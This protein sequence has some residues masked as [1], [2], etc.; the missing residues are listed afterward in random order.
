MAHQIFQIYKEKGEKV[1]FGWADVQQESFGALFAGSDT[2]AISFR[3][4]PLI[5]RSFG[6]EFWDAGRTRWHTRNTFFARQEGIITRL[7]RRN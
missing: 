4:L 3:S 1:D 2:T 7:T 6:L 5:V